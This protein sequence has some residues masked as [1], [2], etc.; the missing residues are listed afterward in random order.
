MGPVRRGGSISFV[1]QDNGGEPERE[2]NGRPALAMNADLTAGLDLTVARRLRENQRIEFMGDIKVGPFDIDETTAELLLNSPNPDGRRNSDVVRP[3]INGLDIGGRPRRMWIIDFGLDM[4]VSEAA[5]YEA[6][7]EYVRRHV[8]PF[9]ST[10]NAE[11]CRRKWWLHHN[12]RP[13]MRSAMSGLS[14]YIATIR[15]SKHRLFAWQPAGTLPDSR[16]IAFARE[17]DYTFGVLHSSVHEI[18][19]RAT[20]SQLR[21][22]ESGFSYTPTTCFETFPFPDPTPEQRERVGEAARRLVELRDGW[23][24][25]PGLDPA[26]VANR[27]LTNLYNQRP[28]WLANAHADLDAAVFAAYGWPNDLPDAAIL[29]CLLAMNLDLA[30]REGNPGVKRRAFR[31]A[32]RS[33]PAGGADEDFEVE[34]D[35]PRPSEFA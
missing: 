21:E 1:G 9:R 19:A 14:R 17:D 33:M 35:V 13:A 11:C 28:T 12:A 24:N 7:F 3:W 6:P 16:L 10:V 22:V 18:W 25:P 34:R 30:S 31:A 5:L 23:L 27:T 26:D 20:G 8:L 15:I 2:L 29:E 4:S 32:L